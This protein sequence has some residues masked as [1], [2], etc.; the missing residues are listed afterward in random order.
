MYY[1]RKL[2]ATRIL[3]TYAKNESAQ[4][5][6]YVSKEIATMIQEDNCPLTRIFADIL[7]GYFKCNENSLASEMPALGVLKHEL[8]TFYPVGTLN[9]NELTKAFG[10]QPLLNTTRRRDDWE[11]LFSDIRK[12]LIEGQKAERRLIY[13]LDGL[14]LKNI[15]EQTRRDDGSWDSGI[16]VSRKQFLNEGFESMNEADRKVAAKM[17]VRVVDK[18]EASILFEEL[19]ASERLFVGEPYTQ[20][21]QPAEVEVVMPSIRFK[22]VGSEIYVS[23]NVS[24]D[25]NLRIPDKCIVSTEEFGK[26]NAERF[27][28]GCAYKSIVF[29]GSANSGCCGGEDSFRTSG[30]YTGCGV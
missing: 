6:S 12:N 28:E 17:R 7:T 3:L 1:G 23:S 29:S 16:S 26:Y 10:G 24:L 21:F 18:P 25:S 13:F 9:K 20:P 27:A 4:C 14:W 5:A 8:S 15:V 19:G 22:T 2:A 30:R 11:I